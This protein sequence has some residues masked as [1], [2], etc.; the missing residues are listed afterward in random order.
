MVLDE[1]AVLRQRLSTLALFRTATAWL[2]L[3]NQ[4]A[5]YGVQVPEEKS[6]LALFQVFAQQSMTKYMESRAFFDD[7][8]KRTQLLLNTAVQY[9]RKTM[10]QATTLSLLVN[11]SIN[12]W[13]QNLVGNDA[14]RSSCWT[15]RLIA[16]SATT[17]VRFASPLFLCRPHSSSQPQSWNGNFRCLLE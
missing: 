17:R 13:R 12:T 10:A 9:Q 3:M 8:A 1:I 2:A 14:V 11:A 4:A 6:R 7:V 16:S 5:C 15:N